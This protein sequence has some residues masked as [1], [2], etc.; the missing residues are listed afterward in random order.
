MIIFAKTHKHMTP[1]QAA[2][3]ATLVVLAIAGYCTWIALSP[4]ETAI[5]ILFG[6]FII[7]VACILWTA[8]F[9]FAMK[10]GS[11]NSND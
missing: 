7:V 4:K 5:K 11:D 2:L 1:K 8:I 10:L 9:F 3:T 6:T